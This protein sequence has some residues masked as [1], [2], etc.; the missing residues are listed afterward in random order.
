VHRHLSTAHQHQHEQHEHQHSQ[1]QPRT[2]D[3]GSRLL[4]I[5]RMPPGALSGLAHA[6]ILSTLPHT[7]HAAHPSSSETFANHSRRITIDAPR[8]MHDQNRDRDHGQA[9]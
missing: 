3:H 7:L 9:P 2:G 8:P 6:P 1:L 5:A 4:S